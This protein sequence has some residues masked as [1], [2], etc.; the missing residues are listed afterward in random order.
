MSVYAEELESRL[1]RLVLPHRHQYDTRL[2]RQRDAAVR[3]EWPSH[4]A[5]VE[6][7]IQRSMQALWTFELLCAKYERLLD[8][9]RWVEIDPKRFDAAGADTMNGIAREMQ[10]YGRFL[11]YTRRFHYSWYD[12]VRTMKNDVTEA[13]AL[14]DRMAA[15]A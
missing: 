8:T 6:A 11:P 7:A 1:Y 3:A 13:F 4:A 15:L 2:S 14:A 5:E 9:G 12:L 10:P